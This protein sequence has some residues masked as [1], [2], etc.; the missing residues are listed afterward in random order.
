[1]ILNFI[2]ILEIIMCL[3]FVEKQILKFENFFPDTKKSTLRL[4][5]SLIHIKFK[6]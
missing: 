1:M 2:L 5:I 3:I 6:E 4:Q